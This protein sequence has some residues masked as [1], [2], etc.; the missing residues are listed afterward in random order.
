MNRSLWVRICARLIVLG[1]FL[2]NVSTAFSDQPSQQVL[3]HYMPWYA[4]DQEKGQFGWHWTMNH[5]DPAKVNEAGRREIASHHYPQIGPYDSGNVHVLEYHALLMKLAGIDGVVFDWYGKRK[6]RDYAMIDR[7][8]R[9]MIPW[10][11]KAGLR[12]TFCYEDQAIKHLVEAKEITP[13]SDID[14]A[15]EEIERLA[16][17]DFKDGSWVRIDGKPVLLIFGPQHFTPARWEQVARK[18]KSKPLIFG[19]PHLAGKFKLDGAFAWPPVTGGKTISVQKW[20]TNLA[21]TYRS[22]QRVIPTVFP[23]FHDIYAE[24]K[25]HESYGFIDDRDGETFRETLAMAKA[26]KSPLIQIATWND[27]GEGTVIEP[28]REFG[29]QYLEQLIDSNPKS[30][31]DKQDLSLPLALYRLRCAGME[32]SADEIADALFGG[33]CERARQI[34]KKGK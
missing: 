21:S 18:L 25:L 32:S 28:T 33:D 29:F 4:A 5:F 14:E 27:F 34:L 13:A 26:T 6:F 31:F 23:G 9:A 20:K 3:V 24:A 22:N 16:E 2:L 10:L 30:K 19:L 7:N 11:K 15:V 12:C 8:T 1:W 17:T